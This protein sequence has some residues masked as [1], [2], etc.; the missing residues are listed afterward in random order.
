MKTTANHEEHDV[1]IVLPE[2]TLMT[3]YRNLNNFLWTE[4][5]NCSHQI[6]RNPNTEVHSRNITHRGVNVMEW[7]LLC[8]FSA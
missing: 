3:F 7:G 1:F 8:C 2:H 4:K 5:G 6:L